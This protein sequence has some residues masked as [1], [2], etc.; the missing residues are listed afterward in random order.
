MASARESRICW[1][2]LSIEDDNIYHHDD[3][4]HD[5]NNTDEQLPEQCL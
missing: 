5:K 4:I 2:L 1:K 3:C